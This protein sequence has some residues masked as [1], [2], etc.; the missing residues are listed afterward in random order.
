MNPFFNPSKQSASSGFRLPMSVL[1]D[2]AKRFKAL[3]NSPDPAAAAVNMAMQS[4]AFSD[5]RGPAD[6]KSLCAHLAQKVGV[7]VS[8]I[9]GLFGM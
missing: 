6:V 8:D 4:P 2:A 7:D 9:F 3:K 1:N 5:Y